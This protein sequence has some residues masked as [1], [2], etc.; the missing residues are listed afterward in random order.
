MPRDIK[1]ELNKQIC[2]FM[3]NYEKT[4]TVNQTQ[5]YTLHEKGGKKLLDIETRN[6]VIHMTWLKAYLNIGPDRVTWT[7]FADMIIGTDILK[8]HLIDTDPESRVMPF[9]QTWETKTRGSTLPKDLRQM[10]RIAK[11]YN[12]QISARNPSKEARESLLIWYHIWSDK[13]ARSL[14]KTKATK[15]LRKKHKIKLVKDALQMMEEI[16]K[17]HEP[18]INCACNSC[19]S[20]RR[21]TKCSHPHKCISLAAT[22]INKIPP[23]WDPRTSNED[24]DGLENNIDPKPEEDE[25]VV[26]KSTAPKSLKEAVIIFNKPTN[27]DTQTTET[28]NPSD[29]P[30]NTT[31]YTD[32]VC[33][34]N[35]LENA[36]A[37]SGIWYRDNDPRNKSIRVPLTNQSNQSGELMAILHTI[38]DNPPNDNLRII[39]D[40]KYTIE[41]LTKNAEN[42]ENWNWSGIQNSEIFK[43]I[44]AWIRSRTGT[45]TLKWTRGHNGTKGNE[46]A[47]KLAVE[48]TKLP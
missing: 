24:P 19:N 28:T 44:T 23:K 6:K 30:A 7:F 4:D 27:P 34:N 22:L 45:T 8:S 35:G 29:I 12:T 14:Y 15:C 41:G 31:I 26:T 43:C 5:M 3:W 40:S 38:K 25:V 1:T 48:G 37:G 11:E 17:L 18:R 32:G 39:S 36:A 10:L 20:H 13:S 33:T 42:W 2:K 9:L 16:N 47:D 21:T 46:E